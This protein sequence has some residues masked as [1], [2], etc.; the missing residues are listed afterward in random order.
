MGSSKKH[1][2]RCFS[3]SQSNTTRIKGF[4]TF[5]KVNFNGKSSAFNHL[6]QFISN[7]K[8]FN[9]DEVV[10]SRIFTYTLTQKEKHWCISLPVALVHNWD[11]FHRCSFRFFNDITTKKCENNCLNCV[12][13]KVSPWIKFQLNLN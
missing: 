10:L 7:S 5:S 8:K 13:Q 9:I 3:V 4:K 1:P 11:E 12:R 2:W 6:L